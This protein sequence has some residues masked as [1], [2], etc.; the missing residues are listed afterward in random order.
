MIITLRYRSRHVETYRVLRFIVEGSVNAVVD[1]R[2]YAILGRL[3]DGPGV[4]SS[5]ELG[6]G[7]ARFLPLVSLGGSLMIKPVDCGRLRRAL[8]QRLET[9]EKQSCDKPLIRARSFFLRF[10]FPRRRIFGTSRSN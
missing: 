7:A 1:R 5:P 9:G 4:S 8:N 6:S 3:V 10:R 2:A